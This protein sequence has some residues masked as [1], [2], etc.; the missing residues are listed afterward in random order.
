MSSR[1]ARSNPKDAKAEGRAFVNAKLLA[2]HRVYGSMGDLA[3][4]VFDRHIHP[5][6]EKAIRAKAVTLDAIP[7]E[8]R[9]P[10]TRRVNIQLLDL[11]I[12][13][14]ID[15]SDFIPISLLTNPVTDEMPRPLY[16]QDI[17]KGHRL[18]QQLKTLDVEPGFNGDGY[19]GLLGRQQKPSIALL[20][21]ILDVSSLI[22]DDLFTSISGKAETGAFSGLDL[23]AWPRVKDGVAISALRFYAGIADVFGYPE[24]VRDIKDFGVRIH[25]PQI[26][27][28]AEHEMSARSEQIEKSN[29]IMKKIKRMIERDLRTAR[30]EAVVELR[31]EGKACGS[32][33]LKVKKRTEEGVL[34][35]LKGLGVPKER[36]VIDISDPRKP[37]DGAVL[38]GFNLRIGGIA[39]PVSLQGPS[40]IGE[41]SGQRCVLLGGIV[42]DAQFYFPSIPEV[43]GDLSAGRVI[44]ESYRG[45]RKK[46]DLRD[47]I[48]RISGEIIPRAIRRVLREEGITR[49]STSVMDYV[50]RSKPNGYESVHCDTNGRDFAPFEWIVRS[51]AMHE[52]AEH[53]G[54]AHYLYKGA[55]RLSEELGIRYGQ[56]FTMFTR[57]E[58]MVG[59]TREIKAHKVKIRV[60]DSKTI[61]FHAIEEM[62]LI[63]AIVDA[64]IELE[65]IK[66]VKEGGSK[67][68]LMSRKVDGDIELEV[69]IAESEEERLITRA[70]AVTFMRNGSG[71]GERTLEQLNGIRTEK[72]NRKKR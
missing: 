30:I 55:G 6:V 29:R 53:G 35:V 11:I 36:V 26:W 54:A 46:A 23:D 65:K 15:D 1:K 27:E 58:Q 43:S 48:F 69:E 66:S 64:G 33:G 57:D 5:L 18:F 17:V 8:L 16:F 21:R 10:A 72:N 52:Y 42:K 19:R 22:E 37:E 59:D 12:T 44:V 40:I 4:I 49:F 39:V 67:V 71:Y 24:L 45:S 31:E 28:Y 25:Y 38:E 20:A 32:A 34:D 56:F 61:S 50:S 62:F 60:D 51:R 14:C 13:H 41:V 70:V 3:K 7:R 2:A 47:A 63:D 9:G 68:Q